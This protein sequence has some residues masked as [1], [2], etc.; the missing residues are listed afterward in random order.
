MFEQKTVVKKISKG[1]IDFSTKVIVLLAAILARIILAEMLSQFMT[2][3]NIEMP[4]V[5]F[6]I[7]SKMTLCTYPTDDLELFLYNNAQ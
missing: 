5:V 1:I 6:R 3:K 4:Y 7:G 2:E